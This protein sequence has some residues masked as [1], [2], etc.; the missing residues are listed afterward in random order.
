MVRS[1]EG[2]EQ[3]G[4]FP[5]TS[6]SSDPGE[7]PCKHQ[8]IIMATLARVSLDDTWVTHTARNPFFH[9]VSVAPLFQVPSSLAFLE[10]IQHWRTDPRCLSHHG[11]DAQI[12]APLCNRMLPMD[13]CITY[14]PLLGDRQLFVLSLKHC[15]SNGIYCKH[16]L[17]SAAGLVL[18][19]AVGHS[20]CSTE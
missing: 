2:H 16:T 5:R 20:R 18:D 4:N 12:L 14:H 1:L 15:S 8:A 11:R 10:E 17:R 13:C 9:R 3:L 6:V 7:D 19:A